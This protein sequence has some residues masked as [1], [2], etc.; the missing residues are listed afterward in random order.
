MRSSV[1][2]L[3]TF[4]GVHRGHQRILKKVVERAKARG[5]RSIALAFGMPPK[6]GHNPSAKP[7][8]LTPLSDKTQLLKRLGIDEVQ[9]LVFDKKTASTPPETFFTRRIL[10]RCGAREMVVGPRVAFGRRRAGKL[11]FLMTLG[12]RHGVRIHVV[13]G[14]KIMGKPVSSSGIRDLLY[15]GDVAG[16]GRHLGYPYS[17]A[18]KVVH[19]SRRG[20]KLGYPTAN[21]AVDTHA[22][23]PPGVFWVNVLPANKPIPLKSSDLRPATHGLCNVGTR[24][25]FTP[26]AKKLTCEVF[27]FKRPSS[28]YGRALRVVFR[29][30]IRSEK[31]FKSSGALKRQIARDFRTALRWTRS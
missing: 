13:S 9:A 29:R 30:R 14:V 18:G 31:R 28:L 19:G 24:P 11:P 25:T 15:Q 2:T 3:G 16:A 23:L 8:L 4:D 22:I 6:L 1:L 17:I 12:K 27:L 7:V 10:Q 20:H 5:A 21:I 26:K